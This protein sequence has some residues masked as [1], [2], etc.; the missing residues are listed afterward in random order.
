MVAKVPASASTSLA[1]TLAETGSS[2]EPEEPEPL[3]RSGTR[4]R[5]GDAV[6][7]EAALARLL[8]QHFRMVWR[9]LRRLGVPVHAV[10]DA[11]Q[12]VFLIASRKLDAIEAGQE[13]R[14][15]YGVALRVAANARRARAAR[16][17]TPLGELVEETAC[18][19]PSPEVLLDRKRARALL[20]EALERLPDDLRTAFV[21]FELEGCSGPEVAELCDVP[22]GTAASRLR[23]AREAFRSAVAELGRRLGQGDRS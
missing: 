10:D 9:A 15:L 14:F 20:D 16:P 18:S 8:N 7:R 3:L 12:E 22:L 21:L 4:S 19:T 1:A 6:A 17:E 5:E 2:S 23:R 11:A 13:R